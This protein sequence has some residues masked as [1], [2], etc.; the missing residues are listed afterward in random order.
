MPLTPAKCPECGGFV[1]VDSEKRAGLCQHCNQPFVVEDAIQTFNTYYNTNN[2]THHNYGDGAVVNVYENQKSVSALIERIFIFLEDGD[3]SSADEYCEKVLD[4]DPENAQAYLGKLM[5]DLKI[6]KETGFENCLIDFENNKNYRKIV[7]FGDENIKIKLKKY[8]TKTKYELSERARKRKEAFFEE[9]RKRKE[10]IAIEKRQRERKTAELAVIRNKIAK[11]Q[12]LI[13]A[14][15]PCAVNLDGTVAFGGSEEAW[16]KYTDVVAISGIVV[17]QSHG[18]VGRPWDYKDSG[19]LSQVLEWED[20]VA[21]SCLS[22]HR[23]GLKSDGT[24]VAVGCNE[25]GQCDVEDWTDIIAVS[26]GSNHTVGLKSDG[27]VIAVGDNE[28]GQCAVKDWTDIV[29]ISAGGL[30]TVGLKTDGTVVA[31]GNNYFGQSNVSYW[32][33]IVAISADWAHT[34]GLK[35]DGTVVATA[36]TNSYFNHGQSDV[37]DWTDIVAVSAG[38]TCS[39]GLKADGTVVLAGKKLNEVDIS[40]WKLF[41]TVHNFEEERRLAHQAHQAKIR[42]N[43]LCQ[44]CGSAFKGFISKKCIICG[45]PKDY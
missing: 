35:S 26:V 41:N 34:V 29:A 16:I 15:L 4:I 44:H 37:K 12:C 25:N 32:T 43:G 13:D 2:I 38:S 24:V 23:V 40:K 3:F 20:I 27:T 7:S 28:H 31:V 45:K 22:G 36:V 8:L 11:F 10:A 42:S 21:I 19:K 33:D 9:K 1:E 18:T 39:L 14:G 5:A 30:H 6:R 17:L